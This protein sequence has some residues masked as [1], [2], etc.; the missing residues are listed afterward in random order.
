MSNEG[1]SSRAVMRSGN[2]RNPPSCHQTGPSVLPPPPKPVERVDPPKVPKI[3]QPKR[4]T[5]KTKPPPEPSPES[6]R[7]AP[8]VTTKPTPKKPSVEIDLNKVI[9]R[10][11]EDAKR[12]AEESRRKAQEA[13]QLKAE[14][15]AYAAAKAAADKRSAALQ[16]S[17]ASLGAGFASDKGVKIDVGGPGGAAYANYGLLVKQMYTS[18]W[19]PSAG[20]NDQNLTAEVTITILKDGTVLS[21][22]ITRR[23]GESAMDKSVDAALRA[24]ERR[25]LPPFPEGARDDQRVFTIEF[26]LRAKRQTG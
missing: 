18:A 24:V 5:P 12:R 19:Q 16:S 9:T 1:S 15:E 7:T 20:L 2:S 22:R 8:E 14:Q 23:S 26:N 6:T 13:A 21:S 10:P 17:L 25:K 3:P 4:P 11:S